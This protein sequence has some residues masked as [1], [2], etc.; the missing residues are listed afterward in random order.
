MDPPLNPQSLVGEIIAPSGSSSSVARLPLPF[1]GGR[2]Q[3]LG[4]VPKQ[5]KSPGFPWSN[6]EMAG[7]VAA[8]ANI[9]NYI[10]GVSFSPQQDIPDLTGKVALVTGGMLI[11]RALL[12]SYIGSSIC[13][14]FWS[15]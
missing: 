1:I 2:G 13:R 4:E 8:F 11:D 5:K 10:G 12:A 14:K 15:W 3:S 9:F 7:F 6:F